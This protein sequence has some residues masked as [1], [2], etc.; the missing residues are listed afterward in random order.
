MVSIQFGFLLNS[1][2]TFFGFVLE[3]YFI[4]AYTRYELA[5]VQTKAFR[6]MQIFNIAFWLEFYTARTKK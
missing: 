4:L 5:V 1:Q 3:K 6:S 2:V